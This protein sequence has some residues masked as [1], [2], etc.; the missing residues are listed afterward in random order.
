ML[1]Q[2]SKF[3]ITVQDTESK[4]APKKKAKKKVSE[5]ESSGDDDVSSNGLDPGAFWIEE[6]RMKRIQVRPW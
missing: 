4:P 2:V 1:H 6:Q 5:S 3:L